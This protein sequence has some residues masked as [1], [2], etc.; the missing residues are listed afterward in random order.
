MGSEPRSRTGADCP[1]VERLAVTKA[2]EEVPAHQARLGLGFR[3]YEDAR[4]R[5]REL[6]EKEESDARFASIGAALT[7]EDER[8]PRPLKT[9]CR[10]VLPKRGIGVLWLC[11][12]GPWTSLTEK[13]LSL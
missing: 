13:I 7:S 4:R 6:R 12:I 1:G 9:V 10:Q 3:V 8:H 2:S 11:T 5:S